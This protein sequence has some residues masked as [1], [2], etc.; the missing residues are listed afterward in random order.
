MSPPRRLRTPQLLTVLCGPR[1]YAKKYEELPEKLITELFQPT[2]AKEGGAPPRWPGEFP[3]STE[4]GAEVGIYSN[5]VVPLLTDT[6]MRGRLRPR[7]QSHG[8]PIPFSA[9]FFDEPRGKL[10]PASADPHRRAPKRPKRPLEPRIGAF[11]VSF[12][13]ENRLSGES[14]G[15]ELWSK[16]LSRTF[17]NPEKLKEELRIEV[18]P[19]LQVEQRRD[20]E[21][22]KQQAEA[23][24]RAARE[25][26][27]QMDEDAPEDGGSEAEV[28]VT[29]LW[30]SGRQ[31]RFTL[32]PAKRCSVAA[33]MESAEQWALTPEAL[34]ENLPRHAVE[35]VDADVQ[36]TSAASKKRAKHAVLRLSDG[37]AIV[38]PNESNE[39]KDHGTWSEGKLVPSPEAKAFYESHRR[40]VEAR[41]A[42]WLRA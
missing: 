26:R 29:M 38:W 10:R 33:D 35:L 24:E 39:I 14:T 15:R 9:S 37:R 22:R 41:E 27:A 36:V 8:G 7:V 28:N 5:V 20:N 23:E 32:S 30:D 18:Q 2:P 16:L 34:P 42:E 21:R 40:L 3:A 13:L 25:Y 31:E 6:V 12:R 11:E 19:F 4:D 17:P 1:Q